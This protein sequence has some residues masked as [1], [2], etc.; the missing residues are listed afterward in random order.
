[1][2]QPLLNGMIAI[3]LTKFII[4]DL[5]HAAGLIEYGVK[6]L[7]ERLTKFYHATPWSTWEQTISK[8]G[9]TPQPLSVWRPGDTRSGIYLGTSKKSTLY[10][11]EANWYGMLSVYQTDEEIRSEVRLLEPY[12][13]LE[14]YVLRDT[15]VFPDTEYVLED[16]TY[17][18]YIMTRPIPR[19]NIQ[20]AGRIVPTMKRAREWMEENK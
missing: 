1:M 3:L 16:G 12:A 19:A 4:N 15:Y 9:L 2:I 5:P 10:F 13:L 7:T 20:L 14:A 6:P 17:G 18:A 11:V 8:E